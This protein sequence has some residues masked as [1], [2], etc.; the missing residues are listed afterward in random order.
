MDT[1]KQKGYFILSVLKS[2]TQHQFKDDT[3]C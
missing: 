2:L 3:Q 1:K